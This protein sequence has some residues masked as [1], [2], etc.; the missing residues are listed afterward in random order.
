[1]KAG[2]I[3]AHNLAQLPPAGHSTSPKGID[4]SIFVLLFSFAQWAGVRLPS[5]P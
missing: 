3:P 2:S 1:L 4:N 5:L